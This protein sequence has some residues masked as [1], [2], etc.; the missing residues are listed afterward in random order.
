VTSSSRGLL[1]GAVVGVPVM[2]YGVWGLLE[3]SQRTRPSDA[4]RWIVGAAV[5]HDLIALPLLL[6]ITLALV[7]PLP[8]WMRAPV[9][10]GMAASAVLGVVAWPE[11]AGYGEDPTNPSLLPRDEAAGLLA[12]V[13][14]VWL[15]VGLVLVRAFRRHRQAPADS[16]S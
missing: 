15:A 6:G 16:R 12:C 13:A 4:V 5:V 10:T 1:A 11:I 2:A 9:R 14:V 3:D 8:S 7:R